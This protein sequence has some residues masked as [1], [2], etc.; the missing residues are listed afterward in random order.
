[1]TFLNGP[2]AFGNCGTRSLIASV[3]TILTVLAIA[4][5]RHAFTRTQFWKRTQEKLSL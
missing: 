2:T 1:M 3:K 4:I 5:K